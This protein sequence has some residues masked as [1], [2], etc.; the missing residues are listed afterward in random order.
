[1]IV[2]LDN[3]QPIERLLGYLKTNNKVPGKLYI[4]NPNTTSP[5]VFDD[6]C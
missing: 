3:L 6:F 1:M 2:S 4:S 5:L